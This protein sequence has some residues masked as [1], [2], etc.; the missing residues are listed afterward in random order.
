MNELQIIKIANQDVASWD[1]PA[2]K[3]ELQHHLEAFAGLCY[4]DDTI[5]NA[6]SDR[7]T[8]N[9][10]KK[11][12][13]D[14]RKAYK[15]KC[16]A[17]YEMLE[18][19]IN[20]LIQ[21]VEAQRRLIDDT[22]K[23]YETRQKAAKEQEVRR[24]YDRKAVSLGPLADVLYPKLFDKKWTNASTPRAK[25]EESIQ[26]AISGA[27]QD[28]AAVKALGSPFVDTLVA[29]YVETLS[30]DQVREKNEELLR[31]AEKAGL[32]GH[33]AEPAPAPA[34]DPAADPSEGVAMRVYGSQKQM[35]QLWDF[36]K[37][38]GVRYE[39]LG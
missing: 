34:A 21:L 1:F 6:K 28:I 17:P 11:A 39:L 5:K 30:L 32:T 20:E 26:A 29:V 23:D 7:A 33:P 3:A 36:M 19:Q 15:A 38:I 25:Y 37:A 4:T 22:V 14:A 31:S 2:I 24:Y 12:I 16:L 8:L 18:P 10:V 13:D 27:C 35:T 9:K